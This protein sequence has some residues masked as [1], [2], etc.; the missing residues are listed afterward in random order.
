MK[1]LIIKKSRRV[2]LNRAKDCYKNDK[3]RLRDNAR[4]KYRNLSEEEKNKKREYG[5]NRYHNMSKEKKQK[6]KEYQKKKNIVK[7]IKTES[8]NLIKNA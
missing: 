5:K 7:L 4:D 8:L 2:I 6:L 3:E 1:Q